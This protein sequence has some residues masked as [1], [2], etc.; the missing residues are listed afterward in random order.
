MPS[1]RQEKRA[2][3]AENGG[4]AAAKARADKPIELTR[5]S[6]DAQESFY[7]DLFIHN[8]EWSKP[9]PNEDEAARW[10]VV[11]RLIRKV[12]AAVPDY[13]RNTFRI[14]DVGCG[15]GWMVPAT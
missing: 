12:T 6:A 8:P 3:N 14:L 5:S 11:S 4:S 15:R 7:V 13:A 9:V 10:S 1:A 2:N